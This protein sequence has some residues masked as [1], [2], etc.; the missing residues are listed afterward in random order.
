MNFCVCKKEKKEKKKEKRKK[1]K[2]FLFLVRTKEATSLTF[3]ICNFNRVDD[4]KDTKDF[5]LC[6]VCILLVL[7]YSFNFSLLHTV[8]YSRNPDTPKK[9][10]LWKLLILMMQFSVFTLC[11]SA[12]QKCLRLSRAGSAPWSPRTPAPLTESQ[13][14]EHLCWPGDGSGSRSAA[15]SLVKGCCLLCTEVLLGPWVCS[16]S[17][18]TRSGLMWCWKGNASGWSSS[19][20]ASKATVDSQPKGVGFVYRVLASWKISINSVLRQSPRHWEE[21]LLSVLWPPVGASSWEG[22]MLREDACFHA[23]KGTL[24]SLSTEQGCG[25]Q[26]RRG[27][28]HPEHPTGSL[29]PGSP[30]CGRLT[31]LPGCVRGSAAPRLRAEMVPCT[32]PGP[33]GASGSGRGGGSGFPAGP[34]GSA[35]SCSLL[36]TL[37]LLSFTVFRWKSINYFSQVSH[38]TKTH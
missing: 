5:F 11:L 9:Y 13:R 32:L 36:R 30:S 28:R 31:S 3:S 6:A 18:R 37:L 16:G 22:G 17:S 20:Q 33:R 27:P 8:M 15:E 38:E 35:N 25:K 4:T 24:F 19:P 12:S 23:I 21:Q 26:P 29:L 7:F 34:G 1:E 10:F 14:P 2:T